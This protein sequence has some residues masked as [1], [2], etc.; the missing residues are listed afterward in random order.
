MRQPL[1]QPV[2][3]KLARSP[4]V[5]SKNWAAFANRGRFSAISAPPGRTASSR[6]PVPLS[7]QGR[8][9]HANR[10]HGARFSGTYTRNRTARYVLCARY[11]PRRSEPQRS[12]LSRADEGCLRKIDLSRQNLDR[13]RHRFDRG[14]FCSIRRVHH[15][16]GQYPS[17]TSGGA[18]FPEPLCCLSVVALGSG[19]ADQTASPMEDR[20]AGCN[21]SQNRTEWG[22]R[23]AWKAPCPSTWRFLLGLRDPGRGMEGPPFE[24]RRRPARR[25][26]TH[27]PL[28]AARAW[29]T[30]CRRPHKLRAFFG[31]H[32]RAGA[33]RSR[34]SNAR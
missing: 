11:R 28:R 19:S 31:T 27:R 5:A 18:R 26:G 34:T 29:R 33:G 4:G 12:P 7:A 2:R 6:C 9:W 22:R 15:I 1:H 21:K 3:G 8:W 16:R 32:S 25:G 23:E 10:Y 14:T 17:C 24:L 20:R 30:A 13:T